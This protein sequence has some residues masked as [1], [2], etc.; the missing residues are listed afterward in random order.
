[1]N[2]VSPAAMRSFSAAA[3]VTRPDTKAR[4]AAPWAGA[5]L[6]G[7][8]SARAS[9][10]P[11]STGLRMVGSGKTFKASS[12]ALAMSLAGSPFKLPRCVMPSASA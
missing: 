7:E 6:P 2:T 3:T 5:V 9:A 4:P 1:M 12:S 10:M 8:A 11:V